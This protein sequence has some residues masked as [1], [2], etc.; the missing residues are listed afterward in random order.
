[1]FLAGGVPV[2]AVATLLLLIDAEPP[3]QHGPEGAVLKVR[4]SVLQGRR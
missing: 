2:H 4:A 3:V 1:M